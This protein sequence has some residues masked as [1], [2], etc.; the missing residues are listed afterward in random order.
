METSKKPRITKSHLICYVLG[1]HG[2]LSRVEVLR[3][4]H[5]LEGKPEAA[6]PPASNHSYFSPRGLG[7]GGQVSAVHRGLV[8][9]TG[10]RGN[11]LLYG[12]TPAGTALSAQYIASRAG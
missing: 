2:P 10:K 3:R 4:V 6:F 9:V 7:N 8:Q 1:V 12:N 11:T 5:V